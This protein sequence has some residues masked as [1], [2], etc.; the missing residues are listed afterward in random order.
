ME[1][2]IRNVL[3]HYFDEQT[4]CNATITQ[5]H[6]GHI[7]KSYKVETAQGSYLLQSLNGYV[8]K[9]LD[10]LMENLEKISAYLRKK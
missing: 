2:T 10:G 1:T 3:L 7:N 6:G 5:I 9:D 8:F 4:V